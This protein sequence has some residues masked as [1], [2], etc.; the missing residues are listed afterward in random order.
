MAQVKERRAF[1]PILE[2]EG[3]REIAA[4]IRRA[5]VIAQYQ[6]A[7]ESGY[8]FEVRYGLG[9][10][11]LR[12]A[13]YPEDFIAALST[14]LQ[15]Y[16][17]ENA[18][19]AERVAKGSLSAQARNRRAAVQTE[20]IKEVVRLVDMYGSDVICKMLVAYGYARD[21]RIQEEKAPEGTDEGDQEAQEI[22]DG[23]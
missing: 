14:F 23:E 20:H 22:G 6:A 21:P 13:A 3:F 11:L 18:R 8:P 19:I 12:A 10:E 17:A 7:R 2:N 5:T 4:A 15:S 9:Q 16:N 1:S